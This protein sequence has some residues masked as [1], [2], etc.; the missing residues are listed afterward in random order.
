MRIAFV[1]TFFPPWRGGVETY[2]YQL[3]KHLQ[4]RGHDVTVVCANAP[5]SA[6]RE[7]VNGVRIEKLRVTGRVYGT[8]VLPNLFFRLMGENPDVIHANFPTPYN[9]LLASAASRVRKIPALLTWH[10]DLPPVTTMAGI[11]V[12]AHDQMLLPL[13]LPQFRFIIA[14]SEVY[15]RTSPILS[16]QRERVVVVMN[17]VDSQRFNPKVPADETRSR[18]KLHDNK[19]ILF[20]G[21]LTAWHGYKGLEVLMKAVA[22]L[23]D[24]FPEAKLLIVG[25]GELVTEYRQLAKDLGILDR[26]IFVGDIPDSELPKYYA[27][28]DIFVLPSKDRSEGFGLTILEANATGKPAIGTRV[29]GIPSVI[30]D[31]YNGLLVRPNDPQALAEAIRSALSSEALLSQMGK[32]ARTWAEQ[33]DWSI[34]AEQTESLYKRA[35]A[36]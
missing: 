10:N 12:L 11:M 2:A 19:V 9:A 36:R 32:N 23:K 6:S 20:V 3:T 13:Y 25:E 22:L 24:Q 18:F 17:G 16:A 27:S 14:T 4:R 26:A 35:L 28:S 5:V 21:A 33:H 8:P 34:V 7:L 15:A 1:S 30:R 29:G 31:G